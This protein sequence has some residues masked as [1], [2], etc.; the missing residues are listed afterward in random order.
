MAPEHEFLPPGEQKRHQPFLHLLMKLVYEKWN[1]NRRGVLGTYYYRDKQ[2]TADTTVWSEG[3]A[4]L[5]HNIAAIAV[6]GANRV[7]DFDFNHNDIFRS[8]I[9]HAESRLV[10]RLFNLT[11]LRSAWSLSE[12]SSAP[13]R[14]ESN[15]Y[16]TDLSKVTLY[17][18]LEPCAQCTGIIA[19]ARIPRVVYLQ[20]DDGAMRVAQILRNL[21]PYSGGAEPIDGSQCG[22]T[23]GEDLTRAFEEYTND[24]RNGKPFYVPPGK[25]GSGQE[26]RSTS[27]ATFLCTDA[28]RDIF[29]KGASAFDDLLG[30]GKCEAP[31]V[32]VAEL[33]E[34]VEYA[35]TGGHRGTPH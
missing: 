17:T 24:V 6:D 30:A 34:F 31:D 19:L 35:L 21:R 28:A 33:K 1:G 20:R 13:S 15:Q 16:A 14:A 26:D 7:I 18:S 23:Y 32:S 25:E 9:E 10:R 22:I 8:S 2:K 11:G 3:Q 27:L 12:M 4:Y 29:A 5:G